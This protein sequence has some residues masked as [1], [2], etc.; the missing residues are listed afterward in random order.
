MISRVNSHQLRRVPQTLRAF[1]NGPAVLTAMLRGPGR[2]P[3]EL[4]FVTRDGLRIS[5]PNQPGARV[6]VYEVFAEDVYDLPW[7]L[8]PLA[9]T[10]LHAVDVGA[11]V[12]CFAVSLAHLAPR[13]SITC[14]EP[15]TSTAAY[16][17][18]NVQQ[19]GL[20]GR[21]TVSELAVSDRAGV[22]QFADNG[23]GSALNG[24]TRSGGTEVATTTFD[25]VV[26]EAGEPVA[27]VKIDC[28]G[29]EYDLVLGSSPASWDAVQRV[30]LE[31]HPHAERGW[32]DLR[33]WFAERGLAVVRHTPLT[34][35][36]GT[37]WLSRSA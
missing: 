1:S 9:S 34:A 13:A 22:A 35:D 19:N 10:P 27:L 2:G 32:P 8:G 25:Q 21:V 18:R 12:G 20:V 26:A 31:Y 6:P 36:Q 29:G 33:D 24:L 7:F 17:R 28:E 23:A 3:D 15:S 11:H 14:F 5:T 4:T 16:L 30:V 37:A